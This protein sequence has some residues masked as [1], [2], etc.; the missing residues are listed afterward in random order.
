M[1]V[2]YVHIYIYHKSIHNIYIYTYVFMYVQSH[3]SLLRKNAQLQDLRNA[4]EEI[5]DAE[6]NT[7]APLNRRCEGWA[8]GF[9]GAQ[10]MRKNIEELWTF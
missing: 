10:S 9:E 5:V 6:S 4:F 7:A 8:P 2:P 1:H 3:A